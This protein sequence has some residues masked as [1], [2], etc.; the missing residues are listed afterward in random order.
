ME[1][2]NRRA[3]AANFPPDK[4]VRV[5]G[6]LFQGGP[7]L[8]ESRVGISG[9]DQKGVPGTVFWMTLPHAMYLLNLLHN[10]QRET[11]APVPNVPPLD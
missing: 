11:K 4:Q 8:A 6:A 5:Q 2:Y 7:T 10:I 3:Q 1:E 9:P